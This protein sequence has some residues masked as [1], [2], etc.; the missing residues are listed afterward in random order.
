MDSTV[1]AFNKN[2]KNK[3]IKSN[4]IITINYNKT[5]CFINKETM[6]L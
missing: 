3:K 1:L 2:N 5:P 4:I 6:N